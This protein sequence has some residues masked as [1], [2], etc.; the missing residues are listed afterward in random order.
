MVRRLLDQLLGWE[1]GARGNVTNLHAKGYF[2]KAYLSLL[3]LFRNKNSL[4]QPRFP[5]AQRAMEVQDSAGMTPLAWACENGHDPIVE[6]VLRRFPEKMAKV[7]PIEEELSDS[8]PEM[9]QPTNRENMERSGYRLVG[10][11]SA[12]KQCRWTRNAILGQGQCYKHT[13]YG[14]N[15]HQ[16]M[17]ATPSVACANKCTFC[18]RNH[19]N[20]VTTSWTFKMD[21]PEW[22]V[23]ESI[24]APAATQLPPK[25][26]LSLGTKLCPRQPPGACGGSLRVPAP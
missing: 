15:S 2:L 22:I 3:S 8:R 16:C 23:Q 26:L 17:E 7:A 13:F 14:I 25:L 10:S 24:R 4:Q 12:V 5:E 20:P 6:L 21:D 18:W 9:M 1:L 19:E 11:H